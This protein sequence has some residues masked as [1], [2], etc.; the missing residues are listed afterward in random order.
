MNKKLRKLMKRLEAAGAVVGMSD[1]LPDDVAEMFI[2]GVME[3]PDCVA[4]LRASE[5]QQGI[6]HQEGWRPNG[7]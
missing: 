4:A 7:H 1:D 6:Q 5:R 2:R 3:C